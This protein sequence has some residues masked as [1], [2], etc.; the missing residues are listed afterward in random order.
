MKLRRLIG[1][2]ERVLPSD[3]KL[4]IVSNPFRAFKLKRSEEWRVEWE[5]QIE[6]S[7]ELI[8]S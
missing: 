6:E 2:K 7:N 3:L 1:Q 4:G 8:K 5:R